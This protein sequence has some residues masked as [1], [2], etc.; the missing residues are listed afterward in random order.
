ME[1]FILLVTLSTFSTSG[2]L[3][4]TSAEFSSEEK[5]KAAALM[6]IESYTRNDIEY[7]KTFHIYKIAKTAL[8]ELGINP[9]NGDV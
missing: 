2:G 9:T 8:N 7:K 5:C 4:I 6:E 3:A 1:V